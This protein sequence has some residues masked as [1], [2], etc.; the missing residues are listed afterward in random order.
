MDSSPKRLQKEGKLDEA[1]EYYVSEYAGAASRGDRF[2]STLL[3][4]EVA[5][6]LIL[7]FVQQNESQPNREVLERDIRRT[8]GANNIPLHSE[9][10]E[11]DIE[12]QMRK[13]FEEEFED[14]EEEP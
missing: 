7:K 8:L 12:I 11:E 10:M 14:A 5:K 4:D 3:M 2:L 6:T 1:L 13:R 9:E